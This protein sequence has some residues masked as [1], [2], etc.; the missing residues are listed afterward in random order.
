MPPAAQ[1]GSAVVVI[2]DGDA[3]AGTHIVVSIEIEVADGACVVVALQ[4]A[5]DLV[6][7]ISQAV[8]KEAAFGIQQQARR[9]NG[10]GGDNDNVG[11]LL[12]QMA[13]G[14]EVG[15]AACASAVVGQDLLRHALGAQL[16]VAGASA[17]GIT[18]FCEP[19]L[20]STSQANPTH[21]RQRMQGPRPL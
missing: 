2:A 9:F 16:A 18:V 11:K 15:H 14:I 10:A 19:F 13:I 7:P 5:A 3:G 6:V 17:M 8:R 12:L 4:I 20:A 21:Q 1:A